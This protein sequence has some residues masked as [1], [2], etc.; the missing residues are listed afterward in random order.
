MANIHEMAPPTITDYDC[1][2]PSDVAD[3]CLDVSYQ[4]IHRVMLSTQRFITQVVTSQI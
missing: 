2:V 4:V 3:Y 1:F